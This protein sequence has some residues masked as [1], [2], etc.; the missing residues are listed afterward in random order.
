MKRTIVLAAGAVALLAAGPAAAK[1]SEPKPNQVASAIC[2]AE[3]H[4]DK[5]AF[6]ATYGKHAMRNCKRAH[7]AEARE[8]VA[9]ASQECRAERAA[10]AE[11]FATTYGTKANGRNA[12]GK[13][14]SSKVKDEVEEEA[15]AFDNAA[16]ECRAERSADAEAFTETYGTNNNKRNAFGKCVSQ[17]AKE[18]GEEPEPEVPESV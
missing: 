7:R 5:A 18:G 10:D 11:A 12:F 15:E 1:P 9:N 16:Q 6:K 13:C 8:A 4:A 3:K 2:K 17:K 14:V